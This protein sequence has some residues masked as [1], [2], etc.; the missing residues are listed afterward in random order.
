MTD[1][2]QSRS[3]E[4]SS[5]A[6]RLE[7]AYNTM[8]ERVRHALDEFGEETGPRL[9][10]A[11]E[12]ARER[13]VEMGELTRE[14]ADR[15]GEYLRRDLN[16]AGDYLARTGHELRDWL[17]FDLQL[18]EARFLDMLLSAADRTRSEIA[19]MREAGTIDHTY[20]T[21]EITAPGTLYCRAC[22]HALELRR[23]GHIPPCPSCQAT[24]F[25]RPAKTP[26]KG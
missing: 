19:A 18:L 20:H 24:E 11:L 16:E 12:R 15:I 22:D 1:K 7:Q 5:V 10:L 26:G 13:A 4:P 2:K 25:R 9:R 14:E 3:N 8:L 23:T 6:H 17:R 21:G